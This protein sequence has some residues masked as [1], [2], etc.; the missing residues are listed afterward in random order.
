MTRDDS[1]L[2]SLGGKTLSRAVQQGSTAIFLAQVVSQIL[3]LVALGVLLRTLGLEPYGLVGMVLPL[4]AFVRIF[5]YSGLDVAAIQHTEINDQQASALFWTQQ[6]LGLAGAIFIASAAPWVA[7]FYGRPELLPLT[8]ALSGTTLATTLGAQHQAMLQRKMALPTLSAIRVLSQLV[9]ASVAV[10]A[11]LCGAGVWTLVI[12]QYAEPL[13]STFLAWGLTGWRPQWILRRTGNRELLRFGGHYTL[14]SVLLF[15]VSNVDKI[16]VGRFLGTQAMAL[17]GQAFNLAQKPVSLVVSPLTGIML[18]ALAHA[19]SHPEEYRTYAAGF[20]RFLAWSMLPC[21]IGLALVGR[22]TMIVLGGPQWQSAGPVLQILAL[23]IPAQAFFNVMGSLYASVGR[24]D[25]MARACIPVAIVTSLSF[26]VTVLSCAGQLEGVIVLSWVYLIVFG[27]LIVPA[28][29]AWAFH[30]AGLP[31]RLLVTAARPGIGGS[32]LMGAAVLIADVGLRY[33]GIASPWITLPVKI[34]L[35]CIVY[36]L[37][38]RRE[39][40]YYAR[41]AIGSIRPLPDGQPAP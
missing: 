12:Q 21:G 25:Q 1:S 31:L 36:F 18:P 28:Y 3:S 26:L 17:Y 19:R 33:W 39:L 5:V 13:A 2:R 10:V 38:T 30:C 20:F 23:L 22:E 34:V 37:A 16:L 41:G 27:L 4:L 32:L 8:L 35:G 29:V 40:L 14:S 15:L 24:A 7:R 11:A 6:I 9:G